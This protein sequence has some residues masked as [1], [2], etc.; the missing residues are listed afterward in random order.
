MY[1]ISDLTDAEIKAQQC[2]KKHECFTL[3]DLKHLKLYMSNVLDVSNAGHRR[4]LEHTLV[5]EEEF[6][7]NFK[8]ICHMCLKKAFR[9]SPD[10]KHE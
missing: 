7:F 4:G 9:L 5:S 10:L 1:N 2:R 8:H 3:R 6:V